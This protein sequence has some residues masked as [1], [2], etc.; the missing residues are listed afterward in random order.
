VRPFSAYL[1]FANNIRKNCES[2]QLSFSEQAKYIGK[3]WR[4]LGKREMDCWLSQAATQ[5]EHYTH[6]VHKYKKTKEYNDYQIYLRGFKGQSSSPGGRA[7]QEISAQESTTSIDKTLRPEDTMCVDAATGRM[8]GDGLPLSAPLTCSSSQLRSQSLVD[9][10]ID[11]L[12]L[13]EPHTVEYIHGHPVNVAE[14]SS[15][16]PCV[17]C[18]C[19]LR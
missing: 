2:P 17:E 11:L 12:A 4:S 8:H 13:Q 3:R 9:V 16:V 7:T 15:E 18:L 19:L 1:L 10:A 6:E 14:R 5:K